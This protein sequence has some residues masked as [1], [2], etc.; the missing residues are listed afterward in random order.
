MCFFV[1]THSSLRCHKGQN[2]SVVQTFVSANHF[3]TSV[4]R[5]WN[6]AVTN[7]GWK[8]YLRDHQR[9]QLLQFWARQSVILITAFSKQGCEWEPAK[10]VWEP[11]S[12]EGN[13]QS[14][15]NYWRLLIGYDEWNTV[16]P[17]TPIITCVNDR[18]PNKKFSLLEQ[19][20]TASSKKYSWSSAWRRRHSTQILPMSATQ[21]HQW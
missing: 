6:R 2:L 19:T 1:E 4:L 16:K 14:N 9:T 3:L 8:G 7:L 17:N 12:R 13:S 18:F 11:T 20:L 15:K 5:D 10:H 21:R